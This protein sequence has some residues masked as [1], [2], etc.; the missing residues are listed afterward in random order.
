MS[1]QCSFLV[2]FILFAVFIITPSIGSG[3]D[4]PAWLKEEDLYE[5]TNNKLK[6]PSPENDILCPPSA[7]CKR[8]PPVV[9]NRKV[10]PFS[11][12]SP[13]EEIVVNWQE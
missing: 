3:S 4:P 9:E 1:A 6:S 11:A 2:F 7:N 12:P 13:S 5:N 10:F 8:P